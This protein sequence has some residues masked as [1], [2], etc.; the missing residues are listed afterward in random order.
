M[1]EGPAFVK[2]IDV[3][4]LPAANVV[5]ASGSRRGSTAERRRD[6]SA[7]DEDRAQSEERRDGSGTAAT[8]VSFTI[9][10]A[11]S[12]S[13]RHARAMV[14]ELKDAGHAAYLVEP[15]RSGPSGPYH[16]RVGQYSTL[17]EATRSARTLEKAL[18]WRMSVTPVAPQRCGCE[19]RR[20]AA[21]Q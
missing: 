20:S 15:A 13:A 21:G 11:E 7:G 4:V 5:A 17:R 6:V 9:Q 8:A 12:T 1:P 19:E 10:V 3:A 2:D 14:D 16:V 18:G